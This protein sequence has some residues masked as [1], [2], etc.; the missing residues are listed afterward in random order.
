[1]PRGEVVVIDGRRGVHGTA[2]R[3]RKGCC[4]CEACCAANTAFHA[5]ARLRRQVRLE[6]DAKVIA[7]GISGYINHG[8]R[9][10]T[11]RAAKSVQNANR[12]AK[13]SAS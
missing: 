7:H 3:Y 1:M 10:D 5:R 12:H 11:C 13:L 9:C 4:R 2:S 8:C 6:H